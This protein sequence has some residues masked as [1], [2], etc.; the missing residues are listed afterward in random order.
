MAIGCGAVVG[1]LLLLG[2]WI[3]YQIY[4]TTRPIQLSHH[5]PFRSPAKKERYLAHYDA[6]AEAWP[7]P[8]TTRMVH[9]S[10]GATFVRVNGPPEGPPLVLVPGANATSLM[11]LPNV[12]ALSRGHRVYA[13]D[14]IYD[15]GKS[16]NV[17]HP[18]I[19][20][21]VVAWLVEVFDGLG[22]GDEVNLV[23]MSYGGWVASQFALEHPQRLERLVLVA[24]AATVLPLSTDFIKRG[25]LCMIPHRRF[26]RDMV[27]WALA[28]A[29]A[30]SA[31]DRRMVDDAVDD[32]WIG[33]RSFK[34]RPQIHPTILSDEELANLAPPTLFLVGE[35]EVIYS[36]S[37]ADAVERLNEVAPRITTEIL[38]DCGHD[39]TLVQADLVNELILEFLGSHPTVN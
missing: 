9:T 17:R 16:V 14:A 26:V 30:G 12:E 23:G 6:R 39:L 34:P 4:Q 13:M 38:P 37:A 32:A 36:G 25:L 11:W 19:P 28:D 21:D 2:L 8:S 31:E 18:K 15:V 1:I 35:N 33:L 24:P 7:W 27:H 22:L 10:W 20:T 3:G 29:A 5:H